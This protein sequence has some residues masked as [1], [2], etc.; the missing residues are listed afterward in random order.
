M[1]LSQELLSLSGE[2]AQLLGKTLF[3][4]R[5]YSLAFS[6]YTFALKAASE[7][8]NYNLWATALG[9]M[10]LLLLSTSQPQQAISLFQEVQTAPIR[11]TK[12]QAWCM[13]IEAEAYSYTGDLSSCTNALQRAKDIAGDS[14]SGTDPY[15]TGLTRSRLASYEGSC[16]LRLGNQRAHFLFW[17][18][19]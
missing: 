17:N 1:S 19:L 5:D 3:D 12:V 18:K 7:A 6:Y 8:Q 15:A 13:A 2:A 9:R 14:L 11:S 4:L 10:S 16:Y